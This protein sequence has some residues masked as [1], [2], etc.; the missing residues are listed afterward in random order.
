MT[1]CLQSRKVRPSWDLLPQCVTM[2]PMFHFCSFKPPEEAKGLRWF[3]NAN[4]SHRSLFFFFS[5]R[6]I[7]KTGQQYNILFK[8]PLWNQIMS[9]Y[10]LGFEFSRKRRK[11]CISVQLFLPLLSRY[12][13]APA[14]IL[15]NTGHCLTRLTKHLQFVF[16]C[17]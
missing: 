1:L 12:V 7:L 9:L 14:S 16:I 3:T 10:S 13:F 4:D 15:S 2:G 6:S 11:I 5:N 17:R 8:C